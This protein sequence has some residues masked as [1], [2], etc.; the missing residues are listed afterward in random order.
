MGSVTELPRLTVRPSVGQTRAVVLVL[1][2]G[3]E[4]STAPTSPRQLPARRMRPF[5]IGLHRACR[6]LGLAAWMVHYRYRGWN[7]EQASPLPDIGWAL[8]RV[9]ERHGDVPVV[10][11]GHSMGGRAALRMAGDRSVRAVA[12]FAPWLPGGEP[13]E[14]LAGRRILIAHG[15]LDRVTS[16]LASHRYADRARAAGDDVT[17]RPVRGDT[18]AMLIRFRT[19]QRLAIGFTRD[20]L[21]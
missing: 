14:Q 13:D 3:T 4:A 9:R 17:W 12:A 18:H 19:W 6:H 8:D 5:A 1:P 21:T 7:G 11:L 2:G 15:S 10:L 16:P 20:S